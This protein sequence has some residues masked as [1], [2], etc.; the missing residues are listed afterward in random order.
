MESNDKLKEIDVRNCT[1]YYSD[2]IIKVEDFDLENILIY[3]KP[4][5]KKIITFHTKI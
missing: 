4:Y 1:Y 3:E 5:E 2:V